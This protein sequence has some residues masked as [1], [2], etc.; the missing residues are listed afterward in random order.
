MANESP[1]YQEDVVAYRSL[2][3]VKELEW[4]HLK[5][6][7]QSLRLEMACSH[8]RELALMSNVVQIIWQVELLMVAHMIL[9]LA[10]VQDVILVTVVPHFVVMLFS[11]F[12]MLM[13]MQKNVGMNTNKFISW[14]MA[15]FLI[16]MDF[17]SDLL[18]TIH[19]GAAYPSV[20]CYDHVVLISVYTTLP[21]AFYQGNSVYFLGMVVS[22]VYVGSVFYVQYLNDQ[23]SLYLLA[24]YAIYLL[25]LNMIFSF[26]IV[27]RD[28]GLRRAI[29]SRYQLVYQN[30]VYQLV[31]KKENALLESILPRRMVRTLQE[32][33]CSRIEDQD[34]SFTPQKADSRK[35]FLEP[36]P[37]VS[38]LVADMVNYTQLTTT[39][40]APQLVEILHELFV[41]FDLAANRN[42]AMRIK[43]LGDAYNCV[44]G[45]PNYFPAHASCCV[46]QALDMIRITQ[47]VSSR[48]KL[49][50]N[51]RIGVHSG[52][53]FAGI[54][55]HTK[56]Q[57]D[58]WSKDVDITNRLEASGLPGLVHVSQMT[59]SMLDEHYIFREGSEAAK[60][61]PILQQA[62]I[63]TFLVSS[64]LPDAV[65]P[66]ELED[67]LS[68]ASVTSCRLSYGGYY[69]E[70]QIKA[71]R[72]I[73]KEVE[74]MAV[75]HCFIE[76]RRSRSMKKK[77]FNEEYL[78][79][80]QIH[81]VLGVFRSWKMEW[82][83]HNLPDLMMKYSMLIVLCAGL[84]IL[85]INWNEE[86]TYSDLLVL[87]GILLVL[88]ILC[89]LA[90]YKKLRLQ[91]KRHTPMSQPS[92]FLSRWLLR[93][94]ERIEDSLFVRVPLTI[95]IL[96][97]LY[98]M[99]SQ[100]V[101]SCDIA[102]LELGIIEA[103]LHNEKTYAECFGPWTVTYC[104]VIVLSL[105]F[106][107][108]GCPLMIKMILG[109]L[110]L[111]LH[112][113]SV[114]FY[115]GFAFER[116]ETTDLG[117]KADYAHTWYLVALFIVLVLRER[118]VNYLRKFNY[119]MRA[120][121]EEAH[122]QTDD[123]LRSMKIIMAN[124]LPS[125]VAQV[126]KV[127]RPHDQLYYENFSKV[128]VMFAS[129]ENFN[130]DTTGLRILHEIICCFDDLLVN[131]QTR[132]KIEK[133]KVMGWTYMVACG[134]ETD[135]YT[136]F[137]IDI[138]VKER[139]TDSEVR[140]RSSVLT[141]HFGST[142]D[143]EMSGDN[144]SQPYAHV[145]DAAVLVMTEFALDLLRIMHDIR[146][147]YMFS[148]YETFLTGSLKIGISHGPVMAGV[149]GLSKP[150]YD[151][152]GHTV[153]M[154]SRMCST[155]LL[156]NIQVPRNTA[157]V[158]RQFNIRCN[159][160]AH[161][162]VKGV[163]KVPTYLVVL[164]PDLTFHE[165]DQ[166]SMNL[167]DSKSWVIDTL[168]LSFTPS[169]VPP[170]SSNSGEDE[171]EEE[172]DVNEYEEDDLEESKQERQKGGVLMP[173]GC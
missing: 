43:F 128:A 164:G 172:L 12:I 137:S 73:M 51:L 103:H 114:H 93:I 92:C 110:I 111:G 28:Y 46:D 157:K 19:S 127:R 41:N 25:T 125:H 85:C 104:V 101:F 136:D 35:L 72:E 52:E 63:R 98:V 44:A 53:V 151:I 83:F 113:G 122:Q 141:V 76:W 121:Y 120:C 17:A 109:L 173:G 132:Y 130:A 100:T 97:L 131:Y 68:N 95:V 64:R 13:S 49:D 138:P 9:L 39:L 106:V 140:R 155:G 71:Q 142:E 45:I 29:L 108:S 21:I 107:I 162:E 66:G 89:F 171:A 27:V 156:D 58:I 159:Y 165:H 91:W 167:K 10:L 158:L 40:E 143:D 56:W 59:L 16:S 88:L 146:Y 32:E 70:I 112:L 154:A 60:S 6:K 33:I 160:R 18:G 152:W 24:S 82:A 168:S 139:E 124:I 50:I 169:Y 4:R 163:G 42:R 115:Y 55:G 15:L 129:I 34:K 38:I 67:E 126:F 22:V 117:L 3:T 47:D 87:L 123:K 57:F 119:F 23:V 78:F 84:A 118:H 30:I 62:G 90:G 99:S 2:S 144:V 26:L 150:H 133:I 81:L 116:S 145:Q 48:R 153:N 74:E 94:S 61:D 148:E 69:E 54:I 147:N 161:T 79:S 65:E 170:K 149:V 86:A 134:L 80:N 5:S 37:D 14:L 75:G 1:Y 36:Y 11:P 20:P 166:E 8:L 105:L 135:H 102:K 96:L 7:C 77:D 31:M